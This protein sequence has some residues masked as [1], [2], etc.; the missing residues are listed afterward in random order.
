MQLAFMI[1]QEQPW[2][3]VAVVKYHF[4]CVCSKHM[5]MWIMN[6]KHANQHPVHQSEIG[7]E[8]G[9]E[10]ELWS[11]TKKALQLTAQK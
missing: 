4:M 1:D 6:L 11:W 2:P 3:C 9:Y 7:K 8:V 5:T 10:T